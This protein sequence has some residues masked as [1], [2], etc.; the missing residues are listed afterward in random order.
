[1]NDSDRFLQT[2]HLDPYGRRQAA[3]EMRR[4][5]QIADIAGGLI[6]VATRSGKRAS[7]VLATALSAWASCGRNLPKGL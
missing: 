6:Q 7:N 1:M 4:A 2:V 5:A 3:M